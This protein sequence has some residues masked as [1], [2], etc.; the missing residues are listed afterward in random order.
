M[1]FIRRLAPLLVLMTAVPLAV[2]QI[3]PSLPVTLQNNTLADANQVMANFNAIVNA[4][5]ASAAKNGVNSDIT[6]LTALS[7]PITP[8]QGGSTSYY[9]GTSTGTAN[10]QVAASMTP[11]GFALAA[12][13]KVVFIAGFTNTGA[14][15]LNAGATGIKNVY[16]TVPIPAGL[17][18]LGG[19]EVVAGMMVEALYDGTQYQLL[20][21]ALPIMPGQSLVY[22]GTS[23]PIGFG[24]EDGS[25][26]S[27][28]TNAALFA[29]I[30]TVYGVGDGAT[31]F[32]LPDSRG[33]MDAGRDDQ[34]GSAANRLTNAGS[35]CTGTAL[36]FGCGAQNQT[37]VTGNL[38]AYTP[39]GTIGAHGHFIANIDVAN[40]AVPTLTNSN[41]LEISN[42][43]AS[44]STNYS[45]AGSA[46]AATLGPT[47]PTTTVFTGTAQG[48]VST[49]MQIVNPAI[50]ANKIIRF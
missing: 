1:K 34:G 24:F 45:L 33:R 42:V 32:N 27:R 15:T 25:A 18:A 16:R 12:N 28:T 37:L 21:S 20:N 6:A 49:P 48:G 31:T 13:T 41:T 5:N 17:A 44:T 40:T 22:R 9:G 3:V 10:A 39:A 30:S 11:A 43:N 26:V 46:T 4:V 35:G 19:G 23:A 29:V 36:G 7:T 14:M 47:S 8:V 50:V 2:A 38:P